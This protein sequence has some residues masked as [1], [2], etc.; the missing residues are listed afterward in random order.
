[1]LNG[2]EENENA[3][4]SICINS[5]SLVIYENNHRFVSVV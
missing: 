2:D 1:M 4:E 3:Q 5:F